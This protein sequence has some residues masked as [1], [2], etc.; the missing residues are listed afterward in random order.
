[1]DTEREKAPYFSIVMPVYNAEKYLEAMLESIIAQSFTNWELILVDDCSTDR[2]KEIAEMYQ[3]RDQRIRVVLMNRNDGVS[4][5]RNCGMQE[6]KGRYLWF[7]DADDK[8][9]PNLLELAWESLQAHPAKLVVFGVSEEYYDSENQFQ[10]KHEIVHEK[11]IY[12]TKEELRPVMIQLEQETLYGYLWNKIYDLEYLKAIQIRLSDYQ[13]AKFIEDI[14]FN[15]EYCMD[16]DTMN[17]LSDCPYH[18]AKRVQENLTNEFTSDYFKF[19]EKRIY[20][21]FRQYQYW[22]LCNS[23]FKAVLGGLYAR[24]ILSAMERNCDKRAHM[25]FAI[26]YRWCKKL[27]QRTMFQELIPYAQAKNSK[28]L[29]IALIVLKWKKAVPCMF[30]GRGIHIIRNGMPVIFSKIKSGR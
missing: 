1:M 17:I 6:A 28:T 21:L 22:N 14:K 30:M 29:S 27:F 25:T 7:A 19:H 16:I 24:Y 23:E 5:A 12:R 11:E 8:V 20:L 18:Y 4:E 26:R 10:Y 15:I 13:S 3:E 2:S 9:D